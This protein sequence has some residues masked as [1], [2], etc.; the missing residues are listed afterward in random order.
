[1]LRQLFANAYSLTM[2]AASTLRGRAGLRD[3]NAAVAASPIA[4]AAFM[5]TQRQMRGGPR[6]DLGYDN[7][8][9]KQT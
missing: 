8:Q 4:T 3:S 6:G 2:R 9:S 7:R 1:M 5:Y